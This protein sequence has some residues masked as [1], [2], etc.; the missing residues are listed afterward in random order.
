MHRSEFSTSRSEDPGKINKNKKL[1]NY[2]LSNSPTSATQL[3]PENKSPP[4]SFQ[5]GLGAVEKATRNGLQGHERNPT[6]ERLRSLLSKDLELQL[7]GG[8]VYSSNND[9]YRGWDTVYVSCP[10]PVS[11]ETTDNLEGKR[12]CTLKGQENRDQLEISQP[13]N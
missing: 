2:E 10:S 3:I 12:Q 11:F 8:L 5:L 9:D 4:W 7:P 13:E 6:F 1:Y